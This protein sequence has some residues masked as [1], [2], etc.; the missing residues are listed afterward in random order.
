MAEAEAEAHLH[1]KD[2]AS[3]MFSALLTRPYDV[4]IY[5][6]TYVEQNMQPSHG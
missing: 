2:H 6:K 4:S 3:E 1:I 5:Y